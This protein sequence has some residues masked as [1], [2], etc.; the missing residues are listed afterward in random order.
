MIERYGLFWNQPS[1]HDNPKRFYGKVCAKHASLQGE[2]RTLDGECIGCHAMRPAE[3]YDL[4]QLG[5]HDE[6]E[7]L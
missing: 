4:E 6:P 1:V 7:E 5:H 3:V 2:R